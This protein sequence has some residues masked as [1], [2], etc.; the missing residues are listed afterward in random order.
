MLILVLSLADETR[1]FI[2]LS[3]DGVGSCDSQPI[4]ILH[5]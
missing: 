5:N 1:K 4:I 2:T 3:G